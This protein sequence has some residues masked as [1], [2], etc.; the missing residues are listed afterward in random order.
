M[1][2]NRYIPFLATL[3]IC[4]ATV[5]RA[6][7]API[8]SPQRLTNYA[9][10][11]V[12]GKQASATQITITK[13]LK[14]QWAQ[15]AI[16]IHNFNEYPQSFSPL[17]GDISKLG[18]FELSD[19]LIVFISLRHRQPTVIANGI[20]R[21][22]TLKSQKTVFTYWQ[23]MNPGGYHLD[24]KSK[25]KSLQQI[26]QAVKAELPKITQTQN[27][28]LKK[29]K[30]AKTRSDFSQNLYD[31]RRISRFGDMHVLTGIAN[32][33]LDGDVRAIHDVYQFFQEVDD[34]A[35]HLLLEK[36]YLDSD[37]NVG[38]LNVI[39]SLGNAKSLKFFEQII[40]QK[41]VPKPLFALYG[42]KNLY[43]ELEARDDMKAANTVKEAIYKH[44]DRDLNNLMMSAPRL[45]SVIPDEASVVRLKKA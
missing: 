21:A 13:V 29:V 42:M 9:D 31:L 38:I 24:P 20:Y 1:N 30:S 5:M 33:K 8:Y 14:G 45:I 39:G 36:L 12:L 19:E 37:Q 34:P 40:E 10:L 18:K 35:A 4:H 23:P 25:F 27:Q 43:L 41:N 44:V 26:A 32:L 6:D 28:L 11:V 22:S 17:S 7:I 3:L 16:T 15:E 2:I